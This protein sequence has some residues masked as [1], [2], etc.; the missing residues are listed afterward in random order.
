MNQWDFSYLLMDLCM[1]WQGHSELGSFPSLP[2]LLLSLGLSWVLFH[3]LWCAHRL[4][5]QV[6]VGVVGTLQSLLR[7]CTTSSQLTVCKDFYQA[8]HHCLISY[9][10]LLNLWLVHLST[11]CQTGPQYQW[12]RNT[13][14][15]YLPS[16]PPLWPCS[17]CLES[18]SK[19]VGFHSLLCPVKHSCPQGWVK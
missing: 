3:L 18:S 14:L 12:V 10:C 16:K 9:K 13:T 2:Q 7:I 11:L 17:R 8:F 1:S 15:S 19:A 6:S 4:Q 5:K